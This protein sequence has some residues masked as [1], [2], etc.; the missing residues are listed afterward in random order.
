MFILFYDSYIFSHR[1]LQTEFWKKS[2]KHLKKIRKKKIRIS[3]AEKDWK[4]KR[5]QSL[6][7]EKHWKRKRL[8]S[9]TWKKI[10]KKDYKVQL[11]KILEKK[12]LRSPTVEKLGKKR[13]QNQQLEKI[14]NKKDYK[15]QHEEKIENIENLY[16]KIINFRN[17]GWIL[18]GEPCTFQS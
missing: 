10:G 16:E 14:E 1:N 6:T 2:I 9:P 17:C 3:T 15:V 11:G 4:P 18:Y 12:R 13:L 8:Q 7:Q 5:L